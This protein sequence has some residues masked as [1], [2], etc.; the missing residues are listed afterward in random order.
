MNQTSEENLKSF[1]QLVNSI[2]TASQTTKLDSTESNLN[3]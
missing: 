3:N 2:V 1:I